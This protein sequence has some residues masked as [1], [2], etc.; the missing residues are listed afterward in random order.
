MNTEQYAAILK[1]KFDN[2]QK[3]VTKP[4]ILILGGTGVGKSS[5]I[6]LIFGEEIVQSGVG[7]PI[8]QHINKISKAGVDVNI[9]DSAGYELDNEQKFYEETIGF[10]QRSLNKP[11][12]DQIHLIWHVIDASSSRVLDY[13]KKLYESVN[14]LS[15]PS[16]VVFSKC[17]QIDE[18]SVDNMLNVLDSRFSF[19]NCF[20]SSTT[21]F[22]ITTNKEHFKNEPN[23]D[24][25]KVIR[26]S[27]SQLPEI[28]KDGFIR[29]QKCDIQLKK[30]H[31]DTLIK[32]Y[33]VLNSSV[34][35]SSIPFSDAP[36]LIASQ[37]AMY[38]HIIKTYGLLENNSL[39]EM[40]TGAGKSLIISNVG[41]SLVGSIIKFI[42][43]IGTVAGGA[44]NAGVA[45]CIT[46]ALGKSL[47]TVCVDLCE[48]SL[49]GET[50]NYEFILENFGSIFTEH[51]NSFY[52]K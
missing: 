20:E 28:L 7:S 33:C 3:T 4:N 1:R 18:D 34:G 47:S 22:F 23:L 8:T 30:E 6:N 12:E 26:W 13:D 11:L 21:P 29:Q 15:I 16:C 37:A 27:I 2:V 25:N 45:G 50:S 24:P 46:F 40:T 31:V 48:C 41:K 14:S 19:I 5:L 44:I 49:R 35:A 36:I 38:A 42:P 10:V 52:S 43:S 51:F 39:V 17:D 9:F 32:R